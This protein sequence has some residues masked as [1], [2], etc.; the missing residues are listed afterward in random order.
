M[1]WAFLCAIAWFAALGLAQASSGDS[2]QDSRSK[3]S[4]TVVDSQG[5]LLTGVRVDISTAAPK[6]GQGIFCPSCYRDCGKWSRTNELGEFVIDGLD[7]SLN[8]RLVAAAPG[9]RASQTD[10]I[11]PESGAVK[12]TLEKLPIDIPSERILNGVVLSELGIP[13]EGAL[14]EPLGAKTDSK[15]WWGQVEVD[16]TV[17]DHWGRFSLIL[18]KEYKAVDIRVFADG[19]CAFQSDLLSPGSSVAELKLV[20]GARVSGKLVLAGKPV[21]N[22]SIAVVQ[23][24]RSVQNGIFIKAVSGVTGEDGTF[25]F[26]HLPANQ[27]YAIF[28]VV[29]DA[30]LAKS[31]YV[32][33]TK[34]FSVAGSGQTRNLGELTVTKPMTIRGKVVRA[35]GLSLSSNTKV[36][37]GRDPAWDLISVSPNEDGTFAIDGL[38]PETYEVSVMGRGLSIVTDGFPY[39]MLGTQSFGVHLS[40]SQSAYDI[41]IPVKSN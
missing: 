5:E 17:T 26:Q 41:S 18:P 32:L 20:D 27:K 37:F 30:K 23:V 19:H 24:D 36:M 39:Q 33:A 22:M 31:E 34:T 11:D 40:N 4:G 7:A 6:V 38:P 25:Q 1:R 28:S 2:P 9:Y 14:V 16:S 21:P 3:F 10:L 13:I 15:R 35:D 12:I 29:G 8:F